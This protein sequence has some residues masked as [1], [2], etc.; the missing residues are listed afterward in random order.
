MTITKSVFA[1]LEYFLNFFLNFSKSLSERSMTLFSGKSNKVFINDFLEF[2]STFSSF[3]VNSSLAFLNISISSLKEVIRF[4]GYWMN[5]SMLEIISWESRKSC[6]NFFVSKDK[7]FNL[8]RL[9]EYVSSIYV[10]YLIHS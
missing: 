5:F 1:L 7:L 4:I 6:I 3:F 9:S 10:F 2:S 8:K